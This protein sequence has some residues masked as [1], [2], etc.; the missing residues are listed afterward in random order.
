MNEGQLVQMKRPSRLVLVLILGSLTAFGP[1]SMD[2]YLPAL[3]AVTADLQTNASLTQLSITTCLLGLAA[4]QIIFGP[5]SDFQGRRK[6]L[7]VTI[8]LYAVSSVLCAISPNIWFFVAVRFLQGL[9]ASAGIVISRAAARDMYEG[10]ELTKFVAL[11]AIVMGAAPILSPIFGGIILKWTTWQAIFYILALIGVIMFV[12]VLGLLPETL[13]EERRT[14]GSMFAVV[15]SFGAL[16]KDKVFV[17]VAFSQAFVSTSMFAYIAASPFV[18]QNIYGVS[19]QQF[20]LIFGLNGLGII[21]FAQISGRLANYFDENLL[22]FYGVMQSL[23]G[24]MLLLLVVLFTWPLWTMMLALFLVVSSVG[25][26][27]TMSFSLGMNRQGKRAGSASAFLG[28]LPFAG[29]A[30]VS[31]LVGLGG[32]NSSVPLGVVIFA[33][34]GLALLTFVLFAW[35]KEERTSKS[36]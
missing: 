34:G 23:A 18:L 15:T 11:L 20:S 9:T 16:C 3:P 32:E 26:V 29:G 7:L 30:I 2:M 33:C 24:S 28:I 14:K 1:L 12:A 22:L 5:L 31:P 27:N 4:G 10:K 8:I 17:G 36:M 19:P 35:K 21:V 25:I 13:E 6:P